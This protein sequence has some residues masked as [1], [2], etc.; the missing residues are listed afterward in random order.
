MTWR[1]KVGRVTREM[2][3]A[4]EKM[5]CRLVAVEGLSHTEA[6]VQ[7]YGVKRN[8]GATMAGR[9]MKR[10]EVVEEVE[11]LTK[12][13]NERLERRAECVGVW[14]KLQR[15]EQLQGWAKEAVQ[16]GRFGDAIRAV[17]EM[18]KMDGSYEPEKVEVGVQGT[19]AALMQELERDERT[20]EGR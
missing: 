9:L 8:S 15:M 13:K 19:F 11:R 20:A 18:N 2:L 6:C 16:E 12:R 14:T 10:V 17:A 3:N 5:F 4:K 1:V 7:A